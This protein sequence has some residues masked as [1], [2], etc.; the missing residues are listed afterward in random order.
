M[1]DERGYEMGL[2]REQCLLRPL[3][4]G[5]LKPLEL[6]AAPLQLHGLLTW[7]TSRAC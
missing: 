1:V 7:W 3:R 2:A 6:P 4:W 5:L